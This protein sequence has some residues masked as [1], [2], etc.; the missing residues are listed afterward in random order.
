MSAPPVDPRWAA[1]E[2]EKQRQEQADK[3]SRSGSGDFVWM[4]FDKPSRKGET[5]TTRL[6][7]VGRPQKDANGNP[8]GEMHSQFWLVTH[9]HNLTIDGDN[10]SGVCPDDHYDDGSPK[11]CPLCGLSRDLFDSGSAAHAAIAKDLRPRRRVYVNAIDYADG[12]TPSVK[13]WGLS[14]GLMKDILDICMTKRTFIE[15]I[16][17]G[18]DLNVKIERVGKRRMDIRYSATDF[19]SAPLDAGWRPIAATAHDLV[20]LA[21]PH[22]L[23]ELQEWAAI[24]DPRPGGARSSSP[25]QSAGGYQPPTQPA[26]APPAASAPP[27]RQPPAAPGQSQAAPASGPTLPPEWHY[28]GANGQEADLTATQIAEKMIAAPG[29]H[30]HVWKDGMDGWSKASESAEI[31]GEVQR[32]SRPAGPPAGPPVP[33][34]GAPAGP[35]TP[36]TPPGGAPAF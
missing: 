18:R 5:T 4:D 1:Y 19:D 21:K 15:D 20:G 24:I 36:P 22:D 17:H 6:R 30:H 27:A 31:Q 33:P 3:N 8:T 16:D 29:G 34:T 9:R 11:T 23:A 28:A 2:A 26:T 10:K 32:L 14:W 25:A 7:I 12:Q 35:P 13:V